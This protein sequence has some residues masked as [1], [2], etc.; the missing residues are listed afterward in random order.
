MVYLLREV[1]HEGRE[2]SFKFKDTSADSV[3]DF[4]CEHVREIASHVDKLTAVAVLHHRMRHVVVDECTE[5]CVDRTV[6][7]Q[8]GRGWICSARR[9][10]CVSTRRRG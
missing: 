8:V 9:L 2:N 4:I 6:F 3:V 10:A 5:G 1:A 7:L